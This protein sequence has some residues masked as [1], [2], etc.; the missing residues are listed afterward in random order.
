ME[1][2]DKLIAIRNDI[3]VAEKANNFARDELWSLDTNPNI[4]PRLFKVD[5][6]Q[7]KLP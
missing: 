6:E 7:V 3:T 4:F 5:S 2:F 1:C